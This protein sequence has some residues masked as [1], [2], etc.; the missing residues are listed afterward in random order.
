MTKN[1]ASEK[2][3]DSIRTFTIKI[4]KLLIIKIMTAEL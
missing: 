3:N 2:E 1:T 4:L